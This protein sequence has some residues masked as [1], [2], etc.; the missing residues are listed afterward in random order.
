M[1]YSPCELVRGEKVN[2]L[3]DISPPFGSLVLCPV[4][5]QQYSSEVKQ[6]VAVVLGPAGPTVRSGVKVYIPGKEN[7]VIRRNIQPMS[8]TPHVIEHMNE[9]ARVKPADDNG[10]FSF[11]DTIRDET[12]GLNTFFIDGA[13][14]HLAPASAPFH[15]GVPRASREDMSVLS[16]EFSRL[17]TDYKPTLV[18]IDY[19]TCL[20]YTSPSP[21]D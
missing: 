13:P 10:D 16:Q 9:W 12:S 2:F 5:N 17:Q 4:S 7:P 3:T 21:R 8:M 20:L 14:P 6:E 1:P 15:S 19:S 11:P 18:D